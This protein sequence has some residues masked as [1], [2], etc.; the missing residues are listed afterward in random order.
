MS[1]GAAASVEEQ[2]IKGRGAVVTKTVGGVKGHARPG[3][4]ELFRS[5]REEQRPGT[6]VGE[7]DKIQVVA[8]AVPLHP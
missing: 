5:T 1:R 7:Y 2:T 6:T 4:G 3:A 8:N